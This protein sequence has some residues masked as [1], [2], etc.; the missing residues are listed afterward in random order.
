MKNFKK[1]SL[2]VGLSAALLA[3]I[4]L[5][6][7][8]QGDREFSLSGTGSSD[9][10]FDNSSFGVSGDLGWYT[11]DRIVWG[12]RQSAS[13]AD[14][15][16]DNDFWSGSTRGYLNYQFGENK[17]R[18]F[19]GANLGAVYGDGVEE[20]GFAGLE[21]GLKY[22]VLDSTYILGRAEYQFFFDSGNE[23]EDAFDDGAWAYTFG[24]GF[25]F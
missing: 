20:T 24:I 4:A 25:N 14:V 3:P 10:D 21:F 22:Y 7:P 23:A 6:Q 5:A 16:G 2:V 11:S 8:S 15:E 9:K 12:I 19:I 17:A 18:P 1:T 13:V